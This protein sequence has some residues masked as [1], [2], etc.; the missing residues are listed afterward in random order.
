MSTHK[1]EDYKLSAVNY[2]LVKDVSQVGTCK[3][4]KCSPR[5]LMRWVEQ[6]ET[7]NNISRQNKNLLHI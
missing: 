2:Y 7:Q 1:S 3:F 6:Y 5:S 4:F